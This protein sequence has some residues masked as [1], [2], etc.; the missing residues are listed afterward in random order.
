MSGYSLF[1]LC[2]LDADIPPGDGR[3]AVLQK[4]LYKHDI[5]PRSVI[6]VRSV[7]FAERV[8]R[9]VGQP[10]KV[11]DGFEIALDYPNLDR[12]QKVGRVDVV[13]GS[14]VA[15]ESV[16][17][18]GDGKVLQT[19]ESWKDPENGKSYYTT[20]KEEKFFIARPTE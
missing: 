9:Y 1:N 16:N 2:V 20:L 17:R 13:V 12:E 7:P 19:G 10:Q 18:I 15:E 4:V 6:D 3:A 5:M 11:T 14:I 8:G